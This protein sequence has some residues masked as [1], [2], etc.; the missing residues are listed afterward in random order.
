MKAVVTGGAGFIGSALVRHLLA[1][2]VDQVVAFDNLNSGHRHNIEGLGSEHLESAR[3]MARGLHL[4][5]CVGHFFTEQIPHRSVVF[6]DKHP[7]C[8]TRANSVRQR[9]TNPSHSGTVV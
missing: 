6:D 9:R 8:M 4:M 3:R 2:G 7:G 5:A 1:Q